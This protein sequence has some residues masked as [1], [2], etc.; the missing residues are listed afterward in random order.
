MSDL[1]ELEYMKAYKTLN[2]SF[3][4][5]SMLL[6]L[7]IVFGNIFTGYGAVP[8][9]GCTNSGSINVEIET[10]VSQYFNS[11]S[12][13]TT[14]RY[15][16]ACDTTDNDVI[17]KSTSNRIIANYYDKDGKIDQA[18]VYTDVKL[19]IEDVAMAINDGKFFVTGLMYSDVDAWNQIFESLS[20]VITGITGIGVLAC[21]MAFVIQIIKL[22]AAAGNPSERERALSGL[23]WTG[24]GT[25]GLG[26]VTII[27]GF[28]YSLI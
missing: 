14:S 9:G 10:A 17:N 3:V 22:G 13:L 7:I 2:R 23:L 11:V 6:C 12:G 4:F 18:L 26:A 8:E 16:F 28:A 19:G 27:F 24:I 5:L 21:V 15:N 20:L 1:S 25:A